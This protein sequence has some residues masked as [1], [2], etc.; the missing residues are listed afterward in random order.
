LPQRAA[1]SFFDFISLQRLF[2]LPPLACGLSEN[3]S[4]QFNQILYRSHE[5]DLGQLIGTC[6]TRL[7]L[8]I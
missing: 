2:R 3:S 6:S 5:F 8:S 7:Y 1:L 4:A